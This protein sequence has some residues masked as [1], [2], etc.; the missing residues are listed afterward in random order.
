MARSLGGSVHPLSFLECPACQSVHGRRRLASAGG[1]LWSDSGAA[2]DAR[3]PKLERVEAGAI[4]SSSLD[5]LRDDRR[6]GARAYA[7]GLLQAHEEAP[8]SHDPDPPLL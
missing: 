6:T 2:F 5:Q 7:S 1:V 4:H 3:R 8:L